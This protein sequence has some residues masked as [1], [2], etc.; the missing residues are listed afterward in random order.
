MS[1]QQTQVRHEPDRHR[2]AA[3]VDGEEAGYAEYE[4]REDPARLVLT[5]TVV[6]DAFE[7]RGLGSTLVRAVFDR[8]RT[9]PAVRE[10]REVVAECPFV[11]R[12]LEKHPEE[13]DVLGAVEG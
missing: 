12:W 10:G 2:W 6:G 8:L 9:E 4:L 3:Y 1:E 5:H 7:G 13:R 11:V